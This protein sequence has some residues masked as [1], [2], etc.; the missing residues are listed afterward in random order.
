MY[1]DNLFLK[2]V[3]NSGILHAGFSQKIHAQHNPLQ[4]F[5]W[6][7]EY[8]YKTFKRTLRE[9]TF[10]FVWSL[11]TTVLKRSNNSYLLILQQMFK[12]KT[13]FQS[14]IYEN[15]CQKKIERLL[16]FAFF[17]YNYWHM[18]QIKLFWGHDEENP[19]Y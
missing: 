17:I 4:D 5:G 10:S 12:H 13:N 1:A 2:F 18:F 8:S 7:M 14:Y 6:N 3:K 9:R 16:K 11:K 15:P 19:W